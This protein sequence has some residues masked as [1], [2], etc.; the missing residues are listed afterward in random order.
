MML[1]SSAS[2]GVTA[3]RRM[4]WR[5]AGALAAVGCAAVAV[6]SAAFPACGGTKAPSDAGAQASEH[7]ALVAYCR[8]F[9][10]CG[11]W[12]YDVGSELT[13]CIEDFT[14]A[15]TTPYALLPPL[16]DCVVD[17]GTN[18]SAVKTCGNGGDPNFVCDDGGQGFTFGCAGSHQFICY[19]GVRQDTDCAPLG[20]M[21]VQTPAWA[22][23]GVGTCFQDGGTACANGAVQ[24]CSY[25]ILL[26]AQNCTQAASTCAA[27]G[28]GGA[29]CVGSGPACSAARC[30][31]TVLVPCA[32]GHEARFDCAPVGLACSA[33]AG[34]C[35]YAANDCDPMTF[36]DSCAGNVLT[37]CDL[38]RVATTDCVAAGFLS[39]I[40]DAEKTR[41]D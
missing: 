13:G 3:L 9:T 24:T 10:A 32:G 16:R 21:C 14:S 15:T 11:L 7:A 31:G 37:Y 27:D 2:R 5:S 35:V 28:D 30:D 18:C 12:N 22:G 33:D 23:C 41:C 25:G 8:S 36:N 29:Q 39:C 19:D 38:G 34:A 6:A 1:S 17:A 20:M 4:R 26:P 40:S